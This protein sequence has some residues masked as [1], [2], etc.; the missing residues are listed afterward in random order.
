MY[1]SIVVYL[2]FSC[3]VRLPSNMVIR[4][5]S[6]IC[7]QTVIESCIVELCYGVSLH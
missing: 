6:Y 3:V 1:P 2:F 4:F 5:Y 7:G